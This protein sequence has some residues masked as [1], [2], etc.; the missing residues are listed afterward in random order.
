MGNDAINLANKIG[1]EK[2][3]LATAKDFLAAN[4]GGKID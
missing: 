2:T 4:G 1:S 3:A